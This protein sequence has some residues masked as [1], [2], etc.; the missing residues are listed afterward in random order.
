MTTEIEV[1]V[2]DVFREKYDAL[3]EEQATLVHG[4]KSNANI[5]YA[6][7]GHIDNREMSI[8]KTNLE[9]AIM[10]AVKGVTKK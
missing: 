10:W 6:L 9:Q 5:V 8:A 3:N 1:E 7:M 2:K 4:I